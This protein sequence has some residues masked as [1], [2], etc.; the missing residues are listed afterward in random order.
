MIPISTLVIGLLTLA[1]A[2]VTL[3]WIV[4]AQWKSTHDQVRR[5]II[6]APGEARERGWRDK[7][8]SEIIAILKGNN[9]PRHLHEATQ[10]ERCLYNRYITKSFLAK[11]VE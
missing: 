1:V 6:F 8:D 11:L 5:D 9:N 4:I 7:S 2:S 10:L 3:I